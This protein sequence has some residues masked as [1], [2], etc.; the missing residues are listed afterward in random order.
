MDLMLPFK[1]GD[2]AESRSFSLGYRG[3][4]F[5]SKVHLVI[6]EPYVLMHSY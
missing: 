1:V 2:I 5:R 4:W 6:W 3:A